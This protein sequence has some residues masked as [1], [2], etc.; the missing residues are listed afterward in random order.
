MDVDVVRS[1]RATPACCTG[2]AVRAA[3]EEHGA[4]GV[5]GGRHR[6]LHQLRHR[7]RHRLDRG[8]EG[9]PRR[10]GCT[11][12]APT[13]S[14]GCSSPLRAT[15]VR[16]RRARRLGH[17]RPAQVAVRAVRRLR[18]DLPRSRGRAARAH[19]ARRVPRH[20]HR[21]RP[22]G[23]RPTTPRTS[24]GARAGCRSGSRSPRTARRRIA[25]RSPHPS[26]RPRIADEIERRDGLPAGAPA[27][28]VGG[29]LRARRLDARRTT[30]AWSARLLE[31]QR[32]FVTP[33]LARRAPEHAVRDREPAD[34]LRRPGGHPRH[35][36]VIYRQ[37]CTPTAEDPVPQGTGSSV[38]R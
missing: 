30:R 1:R 28:A 14:P 31:E 16:R 34:D 38:F 11:S 13:A 35:D 7:R 5:R 22:S 15:G 6:R 2:D 21:R 20:A 4:T 3:L 36:G 18:A 32:A 8:A 17:R 27:A 19:P 24:P 23:A 25:T 33:E 29:R 9:R 12:T 10:S 26:A 37:R